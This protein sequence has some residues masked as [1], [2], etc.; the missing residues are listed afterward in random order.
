MEHGGVAGGEDGWGVFLR[1]RDRAGAVAAIRSRA[2]E[3]VSRCLR[4][5]PSVTVMQSLD[6]FSLGAEEPIKLAG[7]LARLYS[8]ADVCWQAA[9]RDTYDALG[10]NRRMRSVG[11]SSRGMGRR[12]AKTISRSDCKQAAQLIKARVGLEAVSI[13]LEGWGFAFHAEHHHE[14][15]HDETWARDWRHSIPTWDL[16]SS[17][18]TLM[19]MTE[20]GRRV[21]ENSSFGTDHGMGSVMLLVGGG[22]RGGRVIGKWPGLCGRF[23][24][25]T[26]R[27]T[28]G[29]QLSQRPRADS[30]AP[31]R[32]ATS[33]DHLSRLRA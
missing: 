29:A 17:S 16:L 3:E 23:S 21:Q 33:I 5:A 25:R 7:G 20:F 12:M 31:R 18:T 6:D 24:Y 9:G 30:F 13:D 32:R 11:L 22:I 26:W 10:R 19:V 15:A 4:G 14:P 27:C 2:G 8:S 1:F 28:G